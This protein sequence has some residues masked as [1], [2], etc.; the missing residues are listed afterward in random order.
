MTVCISLLIEAAILLCIGFREYF[1][2]VVYVEHEAV[3]AVAKAPH[4][5]DFKQLYKHMMH[6]L[7]LNPETPLAPQPVASQNIPGFQMENNPPPESSSIGFV[8]NR[9]QPKP[10]SSKA[11]YLKKYDHVVQAILEGYSN[12]QIAENCGVSVT[13]VHNVKRCMRNG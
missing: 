1:F 12:K 9:T 2:Y 4:M 7:N 10:K 6:Y 3:T 8:Q 11:D 13:T 5:Y